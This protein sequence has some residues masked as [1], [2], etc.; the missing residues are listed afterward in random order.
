[1]K[2]INPLKDIYIGAIIEQKFLE[3]SMT[4]QEFAKKIRLDRTTVY[5]IFKRKSIDTERLILISQALNFDFINEVYFEKEALSKQLQKKYIALEI[6]DE[7][8]K[9][10]NLPDEFLKLMQKL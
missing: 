1:M 9:K 6:D 5:D 10:L 2:K 8:F 4:T 7:L 3:N